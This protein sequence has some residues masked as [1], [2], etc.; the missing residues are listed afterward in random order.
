MLRGIPRFCNFYCIG[1]LSYLNISSRTFAIARGMIY[2]SYYPA[3]HYENILPR[4]I[5]C[6]LVWHFIWYRV[7]TTVIIDPVKQYKYSLISIFILYCKFELLLKSHFQRSNS[8]ML[9]EKVITKKQQWN[10]QM[11]YQLNV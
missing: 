9:G 10:H 3:G 8:F 7:T 6:F 2:R 11:I 4:G 5:I 1:L